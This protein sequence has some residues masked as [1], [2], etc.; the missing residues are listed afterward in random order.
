M[1][2]VTKFMRSMLELIKFSARHFIFRSGEEKHE[3]AK[4]FYDKTNLTMLYSR[5]Y[6]DKFIS[7]VFYIIEFLTGL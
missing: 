6:F 5:I 1:M 3:V 2:H 4:Y 7:I